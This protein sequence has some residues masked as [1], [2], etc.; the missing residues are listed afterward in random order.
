MHLKRLIEGILLHDI[1]ALEIMPYVEF[2]DL[3]RGVC[4]ERPTPPAP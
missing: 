3:Q 2:H 1:S 4:G